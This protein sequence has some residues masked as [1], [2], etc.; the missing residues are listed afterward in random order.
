MFSI[1]IAL[2]SSPERA[3]DDHIPRMVVTYHLMRL[4]EHV[5]LRDLL[6]TALHASKDFAVSPEH[7]LVKKAF[8]NF[9]QSPAP[10]TKLWAFIT[11]TCS[12]TPISKRSLAFPLMTSLLAPLPKHLLKKMLGD[13]Y[14][15]LPFFILKDERVRTFLQA[16]SKK[17]ARRSP[18]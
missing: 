9:R 10:F 4:S 5:L 11:R 16:C 7:V 13:G 12:A 2:L 15:P 8:G 18:Y 1:L 6:G 3:R 17:H 14:Y